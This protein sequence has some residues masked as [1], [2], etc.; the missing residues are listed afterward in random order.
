M[1]STP[2]IIETLG[3]AT[4]VARE[5]G[6]PTTTVHGWKRAGYVPAWRVPALLALAKKQKKSITA[7]DFPSERPARKP[8]G[9][10]SVAA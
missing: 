8:V 2:E 6:A 3:G 7:A 1:A 10:T 5:I 4:F 9:Q